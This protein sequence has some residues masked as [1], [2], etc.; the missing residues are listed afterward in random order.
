MHD[1]I[2]AGNTILF[3]SMITRTAQ[4]IEILIDSLPDHEASSESQGAALRRLEDENSHYADQLTRVTA[5]A[6]KLGS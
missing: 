4:D 5:E 6:G 2:V 3:S 1:V